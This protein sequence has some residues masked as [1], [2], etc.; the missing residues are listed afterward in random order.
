MNILRTIGGNSRITPN[1]YALHVSPFAPR[2]RAE[3]LLSNNYL[4]RCVYADR[5]PVVPDVRDDCLLVPD[6]TGHS[7]AAPALIP[8]PRAGRAG[9]GCIRYAIQ[10]GIEA[11]APST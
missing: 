2:G 8:R 4:R 3:Y 11:A 1:R 7:I 5:C 9:A 10:A 6:A